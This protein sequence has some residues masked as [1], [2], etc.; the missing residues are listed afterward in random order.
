MLK[1]IIKT[2]DHP[3]TKKN[4]DKIECIP[5][6]FLLRYPVRSLCARNKIAMLSTIVSDSIRLF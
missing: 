1:K 2:K 5:A 4:D 3:H 6:T